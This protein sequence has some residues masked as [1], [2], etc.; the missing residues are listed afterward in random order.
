MNEDKLTKEEERLIAELAESKYFD[1]LNCLKDFLSKKVALS[2][3][4]TNEELRYWLGF[5][6]GVESMSAMIDDIK[7]RIQQEGF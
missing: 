3:N 1:A 2:N 4:M 6:A 5:A 7:K